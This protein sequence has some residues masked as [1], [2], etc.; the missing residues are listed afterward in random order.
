[1]KKTFIVIICLF[2]LTL[3]S[4]NRLENTSII[5]SDNDTIYLEMKHESLKVLQLT[6][7]HLT[8]GIDAYDR[9]TFKLIE[10]LVK[11]DDFDLVVISGDIS[12]SPFG[13]LLFNKL[14][15]TMESLETPWTFVFGNHENDYNDYQDYLTLIPEEIEYL[16]FKTGPKLNDGGVGNFIIEFQ[17][18]SVPFYQVVLMDSHAERENFTE[19]EGIYDYLKTSQI[20]WYQ[21]KMEE[22]I[23]DNLVFMHIPLRQMIDTTGYVGIFNED[24]V[25]AQGKDT[26]FFD[27]CV[28]QGK[29]KG[30][31]FGHDHLNDFY[32]IQEGIIL[33]YGRITG[34]NA[35]GSL[36]R[37]GRV[38]EVLEN[39]DIVMSLLLESGV[40]E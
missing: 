36:E 24:K 27:A 11:S 38:I 28:S 32:V 35:Y 26:G 20:D 17:K 4:C 25:Y 2:I 33:S 29:T 9:L 13:P 40:S 23:V 10:K 19:E 34:Y 39:K 12:L 21:T 5:Y 37:G 7:L 8:Y 3:S 16:L 18:D 30:I 15:T 22:S 31:F 14:L 1:M 6:D